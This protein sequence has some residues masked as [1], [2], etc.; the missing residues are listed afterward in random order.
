MGQNIVKGLDQISH[1]L[2][3]KK[4]LLVRGRSYD[5]LE[6]RSF[7]DNFPHVEFEDFTPNPLY[8]QVCAGIELFNREK[9]EMVVAVGGGS[10]I[11][12]AKCIK[13][14]C[15]L[16][17]SI[18][19]LQQDRFDSGVTLIAVPTTAG[20]G[21]ESTRHAVIYFE[22]EKQSI[23]HVSIVPDY[24][25]LIPAVLKNLP[26]YQKKC[27]MLDALCQAV[28]SWWSV[29]STE[30]SKK[31][32]RE[33][34]AAICENWEAYIFENTDESAVKIMEASNY[35]GRAINITATT[36]AHAMSYK[37]TSLYHFPHGHAVAVCMPEVWEYLL[38]HTDDC[39]DIRG[40]EYLKESLS[41]IA[42]MITLQQFKTMLLEMDMKYPEAGDKEMELEIL[43]KSV[44]PVRLKNYPVTLNA[45]TMKEMYRRIVQ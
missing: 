20:T 42:E 2:R 6:I 9:C 15:K 1:L 33:A 29:N 8:E 18:N 38:M 45:N 27:T 21:S 26:V 4:F 10:A 23:S 3:E 31:Y 30:E 43:A 36:A 14:F 16:D 37:I 44:N 35:A 17:H 40:E 28:E 24:A 34:I 5:N 12:V 25:V 13:L 22:G 41:H 7:F 39:V 11:D 32:S 19:Y